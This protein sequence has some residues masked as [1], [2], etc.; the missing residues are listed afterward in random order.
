MLQK[1]KKIKKAEQSLEAKVRWTGILHDTI[2]FIS[3]H[4]SLLEIETRIAHSTRKVDKIHGI[5]VQVERDASTQETKVAALQKDLADTR[6]MANE[7]A[8]MPRRSAALDLL[9]LLQH[10]RRNKP[11]KAMQP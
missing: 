5:S 7:A 11:L 8:G 1:E 2:S 10:K 6:R 3:Q 4:P 9:T